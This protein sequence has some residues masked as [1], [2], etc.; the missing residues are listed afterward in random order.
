MSGPVG[1]CARISVCLDISEVEARTQ[2]QCFYRCL[3]QVPGDRI[4]GPENV[5]HDQN[6]LE[7]DSA[8]VE[9]GQV[10][11]RAHSLMLLLRLCSCRHVLPV[12]AGSTIS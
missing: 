10:L 7:L 11:F 3:G 9:S 6:I 12:L 8:V 1:G 5:G 4:Q 2:D